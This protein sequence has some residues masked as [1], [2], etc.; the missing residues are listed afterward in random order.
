MADIDYYKILGVSQDATVSQIKSRYQLLA[1]KFHPDHDGDDSVMSLINE[2]YQVLSNPQKKYQYDH[3]DD[4]PKATSSSTNYS[5]RQ[6]T[7]S[8]HSTYQSTNKSQSK[9]YTQT[10]SRQDIKKE[11]EQL[12]RAKKQNFVVKYPY[13]LP[14]IFGLFV[15]AAG[16]SSPYI[17]RTKW[18][19]WTAVIVG[20]FSY[21]YQR[22]GVYMVKKGKNRTSA[23]FNQKDEQAGVIGIVVTTVVILAIAVISSHSAIAKNSTSSSDTTPAQ[24]VIDSKNQ[25]YAPANTSSFTAAAETTIATSCMSETGI[26]NY[27]YSTQVRYCGCAL[28]SIEQ[29]Y[30]L[31]EIDEYNTDGSSASIDT[32]SQNTINQY[33]N[34]LL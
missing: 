9:T 28:G 32:Q 13:V 29:S 19:V 7:N 5:Q 22:L 21:L 12:N 34:S 14:G 24:A 1:K 20:I 16:W 17:N 31:A 15:V 10:K 25:Y 27:S 18:V 30:T 23:A 33:C 3:K 26:A 6:Q 8:T 11:Q 2:A 4:Q